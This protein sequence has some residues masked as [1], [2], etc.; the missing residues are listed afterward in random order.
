MGKASPKHAL[1]TESVLVAGRHP[2]RAILKERGNLSE[3]TLKHPSL[4]V[5]GVLDLVQQ[6][7]NDNIAIVDF[8]TG[9]PKPEHKDQLETYAVQWWRATK[10]PRDQGRRHGGDLA[11][12]RLL[13]RTT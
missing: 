7:D 2:C 1:H 12:Q 5:V 9:K 8:K 3:L 10:L 4:P 11:V 6:G 13:P